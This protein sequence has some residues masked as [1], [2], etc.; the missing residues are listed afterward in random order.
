MK[1]IRKICKVLLPK[2]VKLIAIDSTGIDSFRR[3]RHYEKRCNEIKG[4]PPMTYAKTSIFIDEESKL[5]L[6]WDLVMSREHDVKIAQ[7]I[8]KR[9]KIKNIFGD[10]KSTRLNS[11]HTDIS[12]MPSSA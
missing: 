6:D 10:R 4:L 7:R 5:I 9:N 8:F 1:I 2:K 3:S 12:R 11:S